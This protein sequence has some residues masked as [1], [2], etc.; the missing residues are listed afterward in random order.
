[1]IKEQNG[2]KGLSPLQRSLLVIENLKTK[3][4]TLEHRQ[5]EPIAI[6]GMSCRFPGGANSTDEYWNL[7]SNGINA[8]DEVPSQRWD[9]DQIF[10]ENPEAPGKSYCRHG[11]FLDNIE[12]FDSSF[13]EISPREAISIDPQHRLLLEVSW[14]ALENANYNIKCLKGSKTGIFMGITLNDYE[15]V[16]KDYQIDLNIEAYGVTGL[17]L[18][19]AAGRI[20]YFLGLTGPSMSIDTACSSSLVAIHQA[21]QSIRNNE[22]NMALAGGVNLILTPDTMIGTSKAK[23]LSVDGQCKTFDDSA[24]GIGR[25]EGCGVIVLKRL[26]SAIED[27]DNIL[28]VIKGSAINQD[29]PSSGFTVPNSISQQKLINAALEVAKIDSS[30]INY[31]EAHG[32]GTALGDPIELRSLKSIFGNTIKRKSKLSLA[33]VKTNIGHCESASGVAG[34]I[35]VILQLQNKK[36]A[37][38]LN[39]NK[40][41]TKFDWEN[42]NVNIPTTLQNWETNEEKRVAGVSSFGASGTNAHIIIEEAPVNR[43]EISENKKTT[44][45][46]LTLTAKSKEALTKLAESYKKQIESSSENDLI[47]ICYTAN[48]CRVNF[49]HRLA[50]IA[51]NKHK[52]TESLTNFLFNKSTDNVKYN[53]SGN[54]YENVAFLFTGQG[55]QYKNMGKNLYDTE[56]LFKEVLDFCGLLLEPSLGLNL[57][58]LLYSTNKSNEF[59]KLIHQTKYSQPAIVAIEYALVKLWEDRGIKPGIVMGH[60]VGE[61]TAA[62]VAGIISIEDCLKLIALRGKLMQKLPEGGGMISVNLSKDII[63]NYISPYK[64]QVSIAAINGPNS[65]VISG[66]LITLDKI[67]NKIKSSGYNYTPLTVSHGFHSP[68]MQPIVEEFERVANSV[69]FNK[70][71][72]P[73]I[74]NVTGRQ[75]TTM[76]QKAKYWTNHILCPVNFEKGIKTILNNEYKIMLEIGPKPILSGLG[77]QFIND[78]KIKWINSLS[79]NTNDQSNFFY[80]LADLF[81]ENAN[82]N[83]GSI[84][85]NNNTK[86]VVLPNYP[87]QRKKCWID[88][89]KL[90]HVYI[91]NNDLIPFIGF[92]S[93]K[94]GTRDIFFHSDWNETTPPFVADHLLF[95]KEVVPGASHIS[96]ILSAIQ[97][98]SNDNIFQ[99]EDIYFSEAL[100]FEKGKNRKL[101]IIIGSH[102]KDSSTV[103]INSSTISQDKEIKDKRNHAKGFIRFGSDQTPPLLLHEPFNIKKIQLRCNNK[104]AGSEFYDFM[105]QADYNL[106]NSFRWINEIWKAEGEALSNFKTPK[107]ADN[108]E[109][110]LLFPGLIDS[111]F[112]MVGITAEQNEIKKNGKRRL[113]FCPFPY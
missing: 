2:I 104:V 111:C 75:E 43:S 44:N 88:R 22:C 37:P 24:N 84:Y 12:E 73:F 36:I 40:P 92:R 27:N 112:Q 60:S 25:A 7:L 9:I 61:Y 100:T 85:S 35:K 62:V 41:T 4:N 93:N 3:L 31:I 8:I 78:P 106:G 58:D 17:P 20:S 90:K 29:G 65:T 51:E 99:I 97:E 34:V 52:I 28:A 49:N 113:H 56:P 21:C 13:F 94:T 63:S 19:A 103:S 57:T 66:D 96:M 109:D 83:L 105:W 39:F 32:T 45:N 72:I 91:N 107:L 81:V 26:S 18:N 46:I 11:G 15:K 69:K 50:I 53:I 102:N 30:Q 110:Y 47:N 80:S 95:N 71:L 77:K 98:T 79:Y 74:S 16:I 5:S 87:F 101:E 38:H 70:P 10:S 67:C 33:S 14:E 23:L 48:T 59:E 64:D 6:V 1:M 68:L 82:C 76:V 86:K 42:F 55:S 108:L 89:S 54:D